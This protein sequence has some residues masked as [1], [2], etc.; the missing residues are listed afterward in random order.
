LAVAQLLLYFNGYIINK[1]GGMVVPLKFN[2]LSRADQVD[3]LELEGVYISSRYEAEFVIDRYQLHNFYVDV[4]YLTSTGNAV[5]VQS[6][7]PTLKQ[8]PIYQMHLPRLSIRQ[9]A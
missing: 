5:A 7:Y 9:G 3:L 8:P 6:F 2:T 4:F 1:S